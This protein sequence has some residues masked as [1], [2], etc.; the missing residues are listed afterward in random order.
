MSDYFFPSPDL[1]I[2]F[3]CK[4]YR[5]AIALG[6]GLRCAHS[7]NKIGE[8]PMLIPSRY[9]TC[10]HFMR[11]ENRIC[12]KSF[13]LSE[14]SLKRIIKVAAEIELGAPSEAEERGSL[15]VSFTFDATGRHVAVFT[16]GNVELVCIEG[17][18]R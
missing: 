9:H 2:C 8:R 11:N 16:N 15:T 18:E 13:A 5:H 7:A 4:H 17:S 14:E 1:N 10:V 12:N 3:N 6:Q